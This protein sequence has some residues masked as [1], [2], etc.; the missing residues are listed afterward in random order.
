MRRDTTAWH[1]R[2]KRRVYRRARITFVAPSRWIERTARESPLIGHLP[3]EYVPNGVDT[4][5]FRPI[6]ESAAR[7]LWGLPADAPIVLLDTMTFQEPRKGS[8]VVGDLLA[9][10][11]VAAGGLRLHLLLAGV[12]RPACEASLAGRFS[13]TATGYVDEPRL[14]ATLYN[15]ADL[16]LHPSVSEN[17]ANAAMES[18]A[19][20]TPVFCFD[21]GGM[22]DVVAD[23]ETGYAAPLGGVAELAAHVVE[24]LRA[25]DAAR[26]MASRCRE[27]MESEFSAEQEAR[28]LL[29]VY[30]R[31]VAW[32]REAPA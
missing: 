29:A 12:R 8:A 3:V 2:H 14:M 24:F 31:A 20:G 18:L 13:F 1:W 23:G 5:L 15:A 21:T 32:H 22:R 10:L 6:P 27:R 4:N 16:L 28:R 11:R 19:C 26:R 9:Q 17:L 30:E 7:A 25:P